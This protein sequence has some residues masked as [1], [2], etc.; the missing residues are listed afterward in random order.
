[1]ETKSLIGQELSDMLCEIESLLLELESK[2]GEPPGVTLEGFRAGV[3]IASSVIFDKMWEMQE[4]EEMSLDNRI[5]MVDKFGDEFKNL[6]FI[7]TGIDTFTLYE[8]NKI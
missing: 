3:K 4:R 8:K 5:E 2:I 1:M 6:I 7:Y